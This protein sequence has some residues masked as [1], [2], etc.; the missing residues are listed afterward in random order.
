LEKDGSTRAQIPVG[1]PLLFGVLSQFAGESGPTQHHQ[2]EET[3]YYPGEWV[4]LSFRRELF[5]GFCGGCHGA[6]TGKEHDVSVKPDLLSQASQAIAKQ[7]SPQSVVTTP[8]GEPQGP[9]FP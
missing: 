8:R 1:I 2:L 9:P 3:Q 4:T 6:T 7:S 5:N